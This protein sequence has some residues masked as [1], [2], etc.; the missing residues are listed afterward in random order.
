MNIFEYFEASGK[1]FWIDERRESVWFDHGDYVEEVP[2]D[3]SYRRTLRK[4]W[5]WPVGAFTIE[6]H[7]DHTVITLE[8]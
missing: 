5:Y 4:T 1:A 3:R 8:L 6:R 7:S 2:W